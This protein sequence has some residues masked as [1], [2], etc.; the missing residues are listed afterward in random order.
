MIHCSTPLTMRYKDIDEL[1]R[2]GFVG[3][4]TVAE[5]QNGGCRELPKPGGV[6]IIVRPVNTKPQ[7]LAIGSGGHF[8]GNNPNV[9]LE[10]LKENWIDDTCVV[11]I[12]KATSLKTRVSAYMR[13]GRGSNVGHWGGRLIWQLADA[14]SLLVCWKET[15]ENP[16]DVEKNMIKDFRDQYGAW[17][18]ANLQS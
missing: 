17:P 11:Y 9:S 3:F 12:G 5:M 13:F 7:F 18:Y 6:Y 4:K 15:K 8:K 14:D 10:V 1:K 16:R 2:N